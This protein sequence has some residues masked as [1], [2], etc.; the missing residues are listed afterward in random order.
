MSAPFV[1]NLA[2]LNAI[3]PISACIAVTP[4]DG[5]D[6]PQGPC[7]A[8][9]VGGGG[10]LNLDFDTFDL[11]SLPSDQQLISAVSSGEFLPFAVKRV[12]IVNTTATLIFALY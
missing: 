1:T 12:R 4:N 3:T 6:L 10:D 9:W 7:R 8:L 11:G 5:A 2:A